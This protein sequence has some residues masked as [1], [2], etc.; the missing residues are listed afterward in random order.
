MNDQSSARDSLENMFTTSN[1]KFSIS[2]PGSAETNNMLELI[3]NGKLIR[4]TLSRRDAIKLRLP[5]E[6]DR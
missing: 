6:L 5:N 1:A 4:I 2:N 3:G